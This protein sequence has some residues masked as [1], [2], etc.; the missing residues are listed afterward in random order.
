MSCNKINQ[1]ELLTEWNPTLAGTPTP[2][3]Y[4]QL[5]QVEHQQLLAQSQAWQASGVVEKIRPLPWVNN[6]VHV[7][8]KNGSIRVCIDCTPVNA[9]TMD[10]DWPLP[11]LQDLRHKLRGAR[12]F[13]RIDLKDAFF[14][15]KVPSQWRPYTAY[16]CG[17]Q[18]YQFRRMPFGLKTAPATFQRYMDH[19]LKDHAKHSFWYLDDILVFSD[20]KDGL[21][22]ATKAILR[23]IREM[24]S[25]PNMA[26]SLLESRGLLFAGIWVY[27][28]GIGPNLEKVKEVMSVPPPR[29]KPEIRSA[30]GLVSYLRDH[31]PLVSLL[32]AKLY[33]NSTTGADEIAN[34][35]GKLL[36]HIRVAITTLHH[37]DD[38][39]D[40][41]LYTDA[42]G[43]AAAAVILQ[44]GRIIAV[45]SRKL[46]AAETRYSA[47]D[48]EHLSLRL[49]AEKFKLFLHR[50]GPAT[51]IWND[52][53]AL[54]GR[55]TD[56]L[57]P[58]QART[59]EIVN[60]W[61]PELRHVAGSKNPAD[62]FSR[63]GLEIGG[64]QI[65]V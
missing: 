30:L 6:T 60:Q 19:M 24:G 42:S 17:G 20:T 52:H 22:R 23:R 51:R 10:L 2:P 44:E 31:I 40:A 39:K 4:R 53:Q 43:A 15:I 59:Q 48:R 7:A 3:R 38:S 12:W 11:R 27:R 65:R 18:T 50:I 14:R 64:G 8:K 47:T 58:R 37:W 57:M 29:T 63:W 62:F 35:W 41:D 56:K 9:V 1:G 55:K 34:L 5:S 32:T 54:L 36:R 13:A 61:I 45:T 26:K 46:T 16:L 28:D 21:R 49:S 25:Q 33:E